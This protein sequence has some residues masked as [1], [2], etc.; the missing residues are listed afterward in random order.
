MS[1]PQEPTQDSLKEAIE[2]FRQMSVPDVPPAAAI[3]ARIGEDL[4]AKAR[5]VGT[6]FSSTGSRFLGRLLLPSAAAAALAIGGL[7]LL[8]LHGTASLA[9]AEVVKET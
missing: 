9:L 2:A 4:P 1:E 3:L 8:L 5:P 7:G 6:P